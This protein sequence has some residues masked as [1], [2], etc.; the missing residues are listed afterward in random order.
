MKR[1]FKATMY[2]L[3]FA[4]SVSFITTKAYDFTSFSGENGTF[5]VDSYYTGDYHLNVKKQIFHF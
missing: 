1:Y 3:L 5:T 2:I 4:I